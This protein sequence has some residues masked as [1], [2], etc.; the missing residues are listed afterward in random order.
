MN[1]PQAVAQTGHLVAVQVPLPL[2]VRATRHIKG[3]PLATFSVSS[4]DACAVFWATCRRASSR[5][6]PASMKQLQAAGCVIRTDI[7]ELIDEDHWTGAERMGRNPVPLSQVV[8]AI[9]LE[10]AGPTLLA[11]LRA[12]HHSTSPAGA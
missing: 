6:S 10:L 11:R 12:Q 3:I 4:V 1:W 9:L 5:P 8:G 7:Y 2:A